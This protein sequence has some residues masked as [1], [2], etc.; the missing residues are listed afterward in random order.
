M[1]SLKKEL[2]CAKSEKVESS[3]VNTEAREKFYQLMLRQNTALAGQNERKDYC[4]P[5]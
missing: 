2:A 4:A 5:W 1:V 3:K